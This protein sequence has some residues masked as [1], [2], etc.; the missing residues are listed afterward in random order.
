LQSTLWLISGR[1]TWDPAGFHRRRHGK[2]NP[3]QFLT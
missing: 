2:S 3:P 1:F